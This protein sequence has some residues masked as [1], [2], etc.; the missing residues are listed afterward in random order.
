MFMHIKP[1]PTPT[2]KARPGTTEEIFAKTLAGAE[3]LWRETHVE[4]LIERTL[5]L[6]SKN[7]SISSMALLRQNRDR[8]KI[9]IPISGFDTPSYFD[10]SRQ[11]IIMGRLNQF[12][13]NASD[14]AEGI[15]S[16]QIEGRNINFAMLGDND[17]DTY[18]LLWLDSDRPNESTDVAIDFL[19]RQLQ[20][21]YRWFS[22]MTE[23]QSLLHLDDL[24]GLYNHRYMDVA[25]DRETKRSLRYGSNFCLL[26][27]DLD[28]FKPVNDNFGHLAGSQV[29]REVAAI[30]RATVRDVDLVFRFGGDEFVVILIE[31]DSATGLRTA[32]R[33]QERIEQSKF[34]VAKDAFAQVTSSIGVAAFP[35]HADEKE[36]L[37]AIADEC[38]YES[39]RRG[40]NQCV[41]AQVNANYSRATAEKD[42]KVW[43]NR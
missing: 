14:Y 43:P 2:L 9:T 29:L 32:N 23:T 35:E 24:T 19:V 15:N 7:F 25:L 28:N 13:A 41:L 17:Q 4:S 42:Q 33:I 8:K 12:Q 16:L 36:R 21:T 11:K 3:A 30:I 37:I 38:M 22:R 20:N 27:I 34:V 1:K 10:D 5:Q 31:A 40:K 39:K 26:F 18:V 6:F